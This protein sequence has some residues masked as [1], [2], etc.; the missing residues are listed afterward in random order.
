MV[1][2]F[3]LPDGRTYTVAFEIETPECKHSKKD[4]QD[5]REALKTKEYNARACFDD[6]MFIGQHEH[7]PFLIDA[8]GSDFVLQ[9]GSEVSEYIQKI[10]T[11]NLDILQP[12]QAAQS[13]EAA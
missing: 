7:M 8:L 5:K 13:A 2:V 6:V 3:P 11:G 1:A 12:Q 10:K 9:R 4:L